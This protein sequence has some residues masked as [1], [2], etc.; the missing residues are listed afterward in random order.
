[1]LA[2]VAVYALL[3][4]AV[5]FYTLTLDVVRRDDLAEIVSRRIRDVEVVPT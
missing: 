5:G 2:S 3:T 4:D 1:M